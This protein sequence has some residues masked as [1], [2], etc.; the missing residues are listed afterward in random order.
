MQFKIKNQELGLNWGLTTVIRYCEA[1][2]MDYDLEGAMDIAIPP[3]GSTTPFLKT[4][5]FLSKLILAA[6]QEW[7]EENGVAV[8]LTEK[9]VLKHINAEGHDFIAE[10]IDDYT[11]SIFMGKALADIVSAP[12]KEKG[13][14][15]PKKSR[16]AKS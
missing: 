16:V 5:Q 9:D 14:A 15:A 10:V 11:K 13:G 3:Q 4:I 12:S 8:D 7:G 1:V 6:A 2:G